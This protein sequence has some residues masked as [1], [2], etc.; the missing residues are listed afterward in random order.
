[1]STKVCPEC[2]MN[3][4]TSAKHCPYCTQFIGRLSS[5]PIAD[6]ESDDQFE[7]FGIL[8]LFAVF[9]LV[10]HFFIHD[11]FGSQTILGLGRISGT[12]FV[13]WVYTMILAAIFAKPGPSAAQKGNGGLV[14]VCSIIVLALAQVSLELDLSWLTSL[15]PWQ[16][17]LAIISPLGVLSLFNATARRALLF[18]VGVGI[19]MFIFAHLLR[20][21]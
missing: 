4:P 21:L 16:Q 20:D 17:G 14:F 11:G 9:G 15:V 6:P 10:N 7:H 5:G 1:M 13:A 8:F 2:S 3:I 18:I 19:P 12:T